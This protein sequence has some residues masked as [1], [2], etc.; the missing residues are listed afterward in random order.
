MRRVIGKV[1][2]LDRAARGSDVVARMACSM[3]FGD[4]QIS[5]T[6]EFVLKIVPITGTTRDRTPKF[7]YAVVEAVFTRSPIEEHWDDQQRAHQ[8]S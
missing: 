2:T 5:S 3:S 1:G 7:V 6:C 8:S 4:A